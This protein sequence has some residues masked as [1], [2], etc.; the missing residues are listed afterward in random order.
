MKE[1]N[2]KKLRKEEKKITD[3]VVVTPSYDSK[4]LVMTFP[5]SDCLQR[6]LAVLL[7]TLFFT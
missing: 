6:F 5:R 3:C 1:Y 2:K 7:N 4:E